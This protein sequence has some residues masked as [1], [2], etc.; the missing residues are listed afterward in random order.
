MHSIG[1]EKSCQ[2]QHMTQNILSHYDEKQKI[3]TANNSDKSI[4]TLFSG[5]LKAPI[6]E[7]NIQ[8]KTVV[9]SL[10]T[11]HRPILSKP[12]TLEELKANADDNNIVY[13][14]I[15]LPLHQVIDNDFENFLDNL[16]LKLTGTELL[17]GTNYELVC[18]DD[19]NLI[20]YVEG[21]I[22]LILEA[23]GE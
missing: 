7:I 12:Y 22:S 6:R 10:E 8:P 4:I 17:S 3:L 14:W 18:N 15:S 21:D 9:F 13:G 1:K 23:W 19:D 16:S 20:F 5:L 11:E 2:T